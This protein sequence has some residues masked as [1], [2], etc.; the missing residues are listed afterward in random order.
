VLQINHRCLW[1]LWV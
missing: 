1:I